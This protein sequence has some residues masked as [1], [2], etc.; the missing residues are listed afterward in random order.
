MADLVWIKYLLTDLCD[1]LS[2]VLLAHNPMQHAHTK[3]MKINL[4]F[5]KRKVLSGEIGI[6]HVPSY[7][8]FADVFT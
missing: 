6:C 1:H 7:E 8:Q 2:T 5:I 4:F 3:H